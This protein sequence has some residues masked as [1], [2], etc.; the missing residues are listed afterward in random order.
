MKDG[1]K[2]DLQV[3]GLPRGFIGENKYQ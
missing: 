2:T 1:T 3:L